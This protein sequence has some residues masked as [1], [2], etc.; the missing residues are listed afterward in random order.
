VSGSWVKAKRTGPFPTNARL[1]E[2]KE[3]T[4]PKKERRPE[5]L[6][7]SDRRSESGNHL[8]VPSILHSREG[9]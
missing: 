2:M 9:C 8:I 1:E 7:A 4:R 5:Q 6:Q 3:Q